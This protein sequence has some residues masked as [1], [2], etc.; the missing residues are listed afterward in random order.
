MA[1]T[2]KF[3]GLSTVE[4]DTDSVAQREIVLDTELNQ[5]VFGNDNTT[6]RFYNTTQIDALLA[7]IDQNGGGSTFDG[8]LGDLNDVDLTGLTA[9]QVLSFNGASWVSSS[10]PPANI[11]SSTIGELADVTTLAAQNGQALIYDSTT[12]QYINSDIPGVGNSVNLSA[13]APSNPAPATGDIWFDTNVN[14]AFMYDEGISDWRDMNPPD[15]GNADTVDNLHAA[16]FV[17]NDFPNQEMTGSLTVKGYELTIEGLGGSFVKQNAPNLKFVDTNAPLNEVWELYSHLGVFNLNLNNQGIGFTISANRSGFSTPTF[18]A[19]AADFDSIEVRGLSTLDEVDVQNGLGVSSGNVTVDSGN[20][21]LTSGDVQIKDQAGQLLIG[22]PN[23]GSSAS[24]GI[25]HVQVG[26]DGGSV[27][28]TI[29]DGGGNA[30]VTF[31]H[32]AKVPDQDGAAMRIETNVD[33]TGTNPE[34]NFELGANVTGG[35]SVNLT[36]VLRLDL[37]HGARL[38]HGG[39]HLEP[40]NPYIQFYGSQYEDTFKIEVDTSGVA[41]VGNVPSGSGDPINFYTQEGSNIFFYGYNSMAA[42]FLYQGMAL[43]PETGTYYGS[44]F[45]SLGS[46]LFVKAEGGSLPGIDLQLQA[47]DNIVIT[48]GMTED[49]SIYFRGNSGGDSYRFAKSGQTSIEG[50]LSMESLT[51]DRTFT[52]PDEGGTVA[53]T[54]GGVYGTIQFQNLEKSDVSNDGEMG[55]DSSQGLFVYRTQQGATL[56]P[57]PVTVLDGA[58]VNAGDHIS[59]SHLGSHSS[60]TETFL[61]SVDEDFVRKDADSNVSANTEWQNGFEVRLGSSANFRMKYDGSNTVMRNYTHSGGDIIIQGENSAGTNQNM[62]IADCSGTRSYVRLFENNV[63]RL[64]TINGGIDVTGGIKINS[65]TTLDDYEEGTWTP[66]FGGSSGAPTCTYDQRNGTYTKVGRLVTCHGR[67]RTDSKSGGSGNLRITG[68]PFTVAN[69]QGQRGALS[70]GYA[71]AF[72]GEEPIAGL[73]AHNNT[74]VQLYA[75]NTSN[76]GSY[77]TMVTGDLGTTTNDNNIYFSIIYSTSQ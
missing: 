43:Q 24:M 12:G 49:G 53:L 58:N 17:R 4:V 32:R 18:G 3:R 57:G 42:G 76:T 69:D 73:P 23:V 27:A 26:D 16:S 31:N 59:I 75:A 61:F 11:T 30:N 41:P 72:G 25:N 28:L 38:T 35:T 10:A 7:A 19:Y 70:V 40:D 36:N 33:T 45:R 34:M 48:S 15:G 74:V 60:G 47:D 21:S 44:S 65:G 55:F 64:K 68:L 50:F 13:T 51:A 52:F 14:R 29:N 37:D 20:V 56:N 22:D 67:L 66:G 62:I 77:I 39:I 6:I 9:G 71:A 8:S 1:D 5:V 63:E 2:L 46:T 54:S